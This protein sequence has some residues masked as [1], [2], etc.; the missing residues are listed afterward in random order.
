MDQIYFNHFWW[1]CATCGND[2]DLLRE[3][4]TSV[5]FHAQNIH[6][7]R[8][9]AKFKKCEHPRLTKCQQKMKQW[10]HPASDSFAALQEFVFNKTL[11][12]DLDNLIGFSH[13][14]ILEVYHSLHNKWIPKSTH[15]SYRGML[16][17]SQ[18]AA[19]DF[20]SGFELPQA[21]TAAGEKRY[22]LN[23]SKVT[24]TWCA[25]PIKEIKNHKFFDEMLNRTIE[26]IASGQ[27]VIQPHIPDM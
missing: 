16:A 9:N 4:W 2:A 10:L 6:K 21:V 7:F 20:N 14:G 23:F 8:T 3:K 25:K 19:L 26:I 27:S 22:N 13:T 11:L 24:K 1:A 17:R 18:L 12:K 5:I 15:F